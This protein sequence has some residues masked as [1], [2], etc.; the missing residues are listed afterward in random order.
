MGPFGYEIKYLV[1]L[2]FEVTSST[3]LREIVFCSEYEIEYVWIL[4]VQL[5]KFNLN[6]MKYHSEIQ[7]Q[8][9]S[10]RLLYIAFILEV[11]FIIHPLFSLFRRS[12][13]ESIE[14]NTGF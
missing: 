11:L 4:H 2:F 3:V 10:P 8:N 6:Y 5:F 12:F 7:D 14:E 13:V 9:K 1:C